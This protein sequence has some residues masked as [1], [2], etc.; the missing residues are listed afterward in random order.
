MDLVVQ[1]A[2]QT[3]T[4]PIPQENGDGGEVVVFATLPSMFLWMATITLFLT[5]ASSIGSQGVKERGEQLQEV[6][7]W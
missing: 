3:V 6:R 1:T 7:Y 4:Q 2:P 5:N